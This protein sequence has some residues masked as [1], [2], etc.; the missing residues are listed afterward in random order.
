M[1]Q[2][3]KSKLTTFNKISILF[4]VIVNFNILWPMSVIP[5]NIA[6]HFTT[7]R[8]IYYVFFLLIL[9]HLIKKRKNVTNIPGLWVLFL[10][11][12]SI[13]ISSYPHGAGFDNEMWFRVG[14]EMG[15]LMFTVIIILALQSFDAIKYYFNAYLFF[16]IIFI[17]IS[18]FDMFQIADISTSYETIKLM[19][20]I[21]GQKEGT[22][23]FLSTT[24]RTGCLWFDA[25]NFAYLIGVSIIYLFYLLLTESKEKGV[26]GFYYASLIISIVIL[27]ATLSRG[28]FFSTSIAIGFMM[29]KMDIKVKKKKKSGLV[30]LLDILFN[31]VIIVI[32]V[33]AISTFTSDALSALFE[34]YFLASEFFGLTGAGSAYTGLEGGRF[35]TMSIAFD[36]F[37]EKP[38]WGWGANFSPGRIGNPY[39][40]T[41]NHLG[42]LNLIAKFG[43]VGGILNLL[44]FLI[45]SFHFYKCL[46]YLKKIRSAYAKL[47]Y[48]ILALVIFFILQG[49]FKT[50]FLTNTSAYLIA[51]YLAAR[52]LH[53]NKV[54]QKRL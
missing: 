29:I 35:S 39:V 13:I 24:T 41:G 48:L 32:V 15:W 33:L 40:G 34:R 22:G 47:G 44:F 18:I 25:N 52:K 51:F 27:I 10:L 6:K 4:I 12:I 16:S 19:S 14:I 46:N 28:G 43:V 3:V 37:V 7:Y 36:E 21:E 45:A 1:N 26:F 54:L 53:R 38:F 23:L 8:M 9:Y 17:L 49:F 2:I 11:P 20:A 30:N 42:H 50:V 31:M 5:S